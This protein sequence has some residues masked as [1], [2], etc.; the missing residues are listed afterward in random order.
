MN[1][2]SNQL[3]AVIAGIIA[4]LGVFIPGVLKLTP[5]QINTLAAVVAAGILGVTA[6]FQNR[7][8]N[9]VIAAMDSATPQ[10]QN[11]AI[12]A[13]LPPRTWKMNREVTLHYMIF[14]C[15]PEVQASIIA[16]VD[17]A[18]AQH[19]VDYFVYFPGGNYHI[20]YGMQFGASGNCSG[21]KQ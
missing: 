19:K 6:L 5:E 9:T 11:P 20:N 1:L 21:K 15:P 3:N 12:I 2:T 18:E 13:G 8:T 4:I 16:Q 17:T 7:N 14:D 10:A